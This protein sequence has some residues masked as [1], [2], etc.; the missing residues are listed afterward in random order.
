MCK[1]GEKTAI[2]HIEAEKE[3][4]ERKRKED[5]FNKIQADLAWEKVKNA[6]LLY[7]GRSM[8]S[9]FD[10]PLYTIYLEPVLYQMI[11]NG[12]DVNVTRSFGRYKS[13][14][15]SNSGCMLINGIRIIDN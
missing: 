6:Y 10:K 14:Y 4:A 5:E 15:F 7:H 9:K 2:K 12:L 13:N 11:N 8:P 3:E 1:K